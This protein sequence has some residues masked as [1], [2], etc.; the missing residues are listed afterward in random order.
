MDKMKFYEARTKVL[1]EH[2]RKGIGTLSEKTLHAVLKGYF[3][4][5][6][7][8]REVEI[9]P[10]VADIVGEDGIIEIQTKSFSKLRPKLE[11]FLK[12]SRVTVV[13][14]CISEKNIICFDPETGEV[15]SKRR[16]P[17][18]GD[19]YTVFTELE[20]ITDY[21]LHPNFRLCIVFLKA[22]EYRCPQDKAPLWQKKKRR[23][24]A[25]AS[26]DKIPTELLDE[27]YI[28]GI[29]DWLDFLPPCLPES[30]TSSDM[31]KAGMDIMTARL[32]LNVFYK[33]GIVKREGKRGREYLY[34]I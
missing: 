23:K 13:Y 31:A 20:A 9:G 16:S 7:D 19:K 22:D 24:N 3:E 12:Y 15:F 8:S 30:F 4:P 28:S 21:L 33:A 14:P 5:F 29:E 1:S 17:L 34:R 11:E 32:V 18:K 25:Y 2:N 27:I 10:F 6:E 26:Y